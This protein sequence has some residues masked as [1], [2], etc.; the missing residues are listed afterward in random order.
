MP[1]APTYPGVYIEEVPSGVRTI[2]AVGTAVTAFVGYTPKGPVGE[3]RTVFNFGE[4]ERVYGGLHRDSEL[5]YALRQ[6]FG[7]GGS[8]AVIVRV[9]DGAVRSG[10]SL[11]AGPPETGSESLR[12]RALSAGDW[13]NHLQVSVD[14][15]TSSPGSYFNLTVEEFV[16]RG[17]DVVP[18]RPAEVHRNLSMSSRS[19]R[20]VERVVNDA[21]ELVRVERIV[22]TAE[23]T[24]RPAGWSRSGNLS[25]LVLG[26]LPQRHRAI[27]LIIDGDGPHDVRVITQG[28]AVPA[29]RDALA[30][31][32]ED[33]I[34]AAN[35]GS[36][37][38]NGATV[39]HAGDRLTITSGT[40]A[41][42][43]REGSSVRVVPAG[44]DDATAL[45]RLGIA[46]GGREREAMAD[47]RPAPNG[48]LGDAVP[49]ADLAGIDA[50]KELSIIAKGGDRP[51]STPIVDDIGDPATLAA[52]ASALQAVIRTG[53]AGD[54]RLRDAVV[55]VVDD[56]LLVQAGGEGLTSRI[57]F[58]GDVADAL[59]LPAAGGAIVSGRRYGVVAG[60]LG[61]QH[62]T[63]AGV[64]GTPPGGAGSIIGVAADGTGL[65]ALEK[66]DFNLLCI[67]LA[68]QL[69]S[70]AQGA[71]VYTEALALCERRRAFLLVDPPLSHT[72]H[73]QVRTWFENV[74][75]STPAHKNAAVYF[76]AVRVTDPLDEFRPRKIAAS[77]TMAA[78]Y[79]RTD[80]A[81]GVWKAPAGID[82]ALAGIHSLAVELTEPQI[83]QLNQRAIN[84][85]RLLPP[86]GRISWGARTMRGNDQIGDADNK[87]VPVRRLTLFIEESLYRGL[88]W[89]VFEPNDEPLWRQIRL[90]AGTFLHGLFRQGAFAGLS[91]RESYFV[92]CDR[93]T[94][95]PED[96][97]RGVVNVV[98]GFRPLKPAE[99]VIVRIQQMAGQPQ[100]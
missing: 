40:P 2:A 84:T 62:T 41:G 56:Q 75:P 78:L 52:A 21:S 20:Y 28:S 57:E 99:F 4:Y 36:P 55:T 73:E 35:P 27:G 82:A 51:D 60:D 71:Q 66:P 13:A 77:S 43:D 47:V 5:G 88:H 70:E 10:F 18:G 44:A 9:A 76:P 8:E 91:P 16:R 48:T 100:G 79:A 85:L 86:Y 30:V 49:A 92:K 11:A 29:D 7:G 63:T 94:T 81:R 69:G 93:E 87:Y 46:G 68:A 80:T 65:H 53:P 59:N 89:V 3:A 32:I 42:A 58:T 37:S 72:R 14:Y 74:F 98:V 67:P 39:T 22:P 24:G 64:N 23:I 45:L 17:A 33:A 97:D 83:G 19:S 38:W 54:A 96:I 25:A 26:D 12:V 6:F 15:D 95:L 31:R 61:A 1:V 50:T 34:Q 90:N